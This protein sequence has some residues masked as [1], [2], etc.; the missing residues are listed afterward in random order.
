MTP[1]H[2]N[3]LLWCNFPSGCATTC[4]C[5][6][7]LKVVCVPLNQ[8][9]CELFGVHAY[10]CHCALTVLLDFCRGHL[11]WCIGSTCVGRASCSPPAAEGFTAGFCLAEAPVGREGEWG[12]LQIHRLTCVCTYTPHTHYLYATLPVDRI[13]QHEVGQ[14]IDPV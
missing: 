12:G 6:Y 5:T 13:A 11:H 8:Y 9:M 14:P 3:K 1:V 7:M 10:S 4:L 2:C